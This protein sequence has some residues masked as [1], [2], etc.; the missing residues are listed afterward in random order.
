MHQHVSILAVFAVQIAWVKALQYYRYLIDDS[1]AQAYYGEPCIGS[2]LKA[3]PIG[4]L[5]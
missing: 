3:L 5:L 1:T 4:S 2:A